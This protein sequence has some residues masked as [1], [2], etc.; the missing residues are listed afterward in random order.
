MFFTNMI[1][2]ELEE[3]NIDKINM[4]YLNKLHSISLAKKAT[5][6]RIFKNKR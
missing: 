1:K 5:E 4:Y 2:Q 6:E 3:P